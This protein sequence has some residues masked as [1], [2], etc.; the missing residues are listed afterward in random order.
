MS[1]I[2]GRFISNW[3]TREDLYIYIYI[4]LY[5]A[6]FSTKEKQDIHQMEFRLC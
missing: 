3:A 4:Y 2:T 6:S 1:C 5:L